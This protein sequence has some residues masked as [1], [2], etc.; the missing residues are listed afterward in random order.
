MKRLTWVISES[1]A[2]R[3]RVVEGGELFGYFKE[4]GLKVGA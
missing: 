1:C 4:Q 2:Q 3:E